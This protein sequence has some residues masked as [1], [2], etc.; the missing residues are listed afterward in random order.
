MVQTLEQHFDIFSGT[1]EKDAIWIEVVVGLASAREEIER[2]ARKVSGL[3]FVF[4][5]RTGT[6]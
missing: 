6:D 1:Q 2:Q 4:S 3:Y 5:A